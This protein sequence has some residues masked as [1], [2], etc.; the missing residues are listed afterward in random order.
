MIE[1]S[2][3]SVTDVMQL[4]G[5]KQS[6]AYAIIKMCNSELQKKGYITVS[7]RVPKRYLNE[8][9]YANETE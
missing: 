4:F 8:R 6:K 1:P 9:M 5:I 2:Y 7:G 3:Y